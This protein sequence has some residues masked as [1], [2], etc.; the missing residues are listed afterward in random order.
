MSIVKVTGM[1]Y[2][3]MQPSVPYIVVSH[4]NMQVT[5]SEHMLD[6]VEYSQVQC[7]YSDLIVNMRTIHRPQADNTVVYN[8]G[9]HY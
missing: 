2:I 7:A 9:G 8:N 3:D 5:F 1:A 4:I 6:L